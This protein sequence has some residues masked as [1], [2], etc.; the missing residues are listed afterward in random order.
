MQRRAILKGLLAGVPVAAAAATAASASF[1]REKT[2]Q[3]RSSLEQRFEELK[4]R[5][6]QADERN[7]KMLRLA[8]GAAALSLG[9]D[10][11]S[12]I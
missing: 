8:L 5:F 11:S 1:I 9:I 7:K 4:S 6:E 2:E 10:I 3:T 12:L